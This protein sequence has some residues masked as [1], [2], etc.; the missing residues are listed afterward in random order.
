MATHNAINLV[1]GQDKRFFDKL[2]G[3]A[4][5]VGRVLVI[6]TESIALMAFLYR[7]SL[8][9][10]LIDLRDEIKDRQ[11]IVSLLKESEA[12]YR[13]LQA[14]LAYASQIEKQKEQTP[15]TLADLVKMATGKLVFNSLTVNQNTIQIDAN[16]PSVSSLSSFINQLKKYPTVKTVSIDRIENKG[17]IATINISITATLENADTAK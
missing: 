9:Y 13:N 8:D 4:F 16:A 15:K 7:F 3:W 17:S 5:T 6:F 10:R 11:T 1:R 2:I 12:T 14:R